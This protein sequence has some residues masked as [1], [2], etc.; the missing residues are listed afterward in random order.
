MVRRPSVPLGVAGVGD[1]PIRGAG[2]EPPR[3]QW[4]A[5]PP[6][7][8]DLPFRPVLVCPSEP[9]G[10]LPFRAP[11]KG[12]LARGSWTRSGPLCR[13]CGAPARASSSGPT[14][15]P[16]LSSGRLVPSTSA[17]PPPNERLECSSHLNGWPRLR[18]LAC[19]PLRPNGAS[20]TAA[21]PA[22]GDHGRNCSQRVG[23]VPAGVSSCRWRPLRARCERRGTPAAWPEGDCRR[24]LPS[25]VRSRRHGRGRPS[26]DGPAAD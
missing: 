20:A 24:G 18:G 9:A 8:L 5:H 19:H 12:L 3:G 17:P 26:G 6:A 11:I 10:P 1:E 25:R 4:L 23:K 7:A 2:H 21:V 15:A 13:L 14:S 16:G 22:F